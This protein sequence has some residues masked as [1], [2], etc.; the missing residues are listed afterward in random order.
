M[1]SPQSVPELPGDAAEEAKGGG[2]RRRGSS[3]G[4]SDRPPSNS[5][6]LELGTILADRY[7][8]EALLGEGGMGKVYRAEHVHMR[9]QV[10]LKVLHGDV[11]TTPEVVARF[12]RE[13][14]AAGK[15]A[16]PNVAGATDFG[17]LP[18][19]SFFLVLEYVAGHDLRSVI[20]QGKM[21]PERAVHI[22]QQIAGAV[23]AAHA[24]GIIHR[25]LKPENIMLVERDGE[26]DFVKVLDFGIA[27]LESVGIVDPRAETLS[28]GA[29]TSGP[30]PLTRM[31]AVFG[32]PDY[33]SPEQALGQPIDARADLYSLGVMLYELLSGER[34][35]RG[36]AVTLMRQHV[37]QDAP[38]LPASVS[39]AVDPRLSAVIQKLLQKSPQDRYASAAELSAVL[40]EL[41]TT[42]PPPVMLNVPSSP[43]RPS[44]GSLNATGPG[45]DLAAGRADSLSEL[46][47]PRKKSRAGR[48]LLTLLVLG[49][50]GW[51]VVAEKTPIHLSDWTNRIPMPSSMTSTTPATVNATK[52]ADVPSASASPATAALQV[53]PPAVPSSGPSAFASASPPAPAIPPAPTDSAGAAPASPA[54]PEA[55][56]A[57]GA[58][59]ETTVVVTAPPSS[60]PQAAAANPPSPPPPPVAAGNSPPPHHTTFHQPAHTGSVKHHPQHPQ[61]HG[62]SSG[63]NIPPVS[64]W[65]K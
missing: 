25:D 46:R 17:R 47:A 40:G 3:P 22:V 14:V 15:I 29:P 16:H 34:P 44:F 30:Q 31:G 9:K 52:P 19:G 61:K 6:T 13:A 45:V 1:P 39:E 2:P 8:I 5:G 21:A 41:F 26:P 38:P 55:P 64:Q 33:M 23:G 63:F 7:R 43:T 60:P 11:S 59:D 28:G 49:V 36:G 56:V 57:S 50:G 27:K 48:W 4:L 65:F 18:D 58:P 32:T 54:S 10:A 37:L 53:A 20:K 42:Q 24:A 35:F 51:F 62:G 12:E